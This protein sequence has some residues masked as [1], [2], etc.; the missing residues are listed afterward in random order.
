MQFIYLNLSALTLH[1]FDSYEA[2]LQYRKNQGVSM[3]FVRV[4]YDK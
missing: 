2:M 3:K 1:T 4:T